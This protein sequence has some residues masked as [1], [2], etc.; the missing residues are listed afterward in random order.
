MAVNIRALLAALLPS[1]QVNGILRAMLPSAVMFVAAH[2]WLPAGVA[3]EIGAALVTALCAYWSYVTNS[4]DNVIINAADH[5]DVHEVVV[6]PRLAQKLDH[7]K[8]VSL[9]NKQTS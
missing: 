2:H 4:S 6:S 5:T 9:D 1:N 7:D 8:V 3:N